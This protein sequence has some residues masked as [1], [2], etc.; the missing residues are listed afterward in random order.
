MLERQLACIDNAKTVNACKGI[1]FLDKERNQCGDPNKTVQL[2]NRQHQKTKQL[3]RHRKRITG[4]LEQFKRLE[5]DTFIDTHA[6][7]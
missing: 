3:T 4:T 1:Q 2:C 5:N 7:A 6:Y